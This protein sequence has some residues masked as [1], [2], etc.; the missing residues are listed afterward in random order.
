MFGIGTMLIQTHVLSKIDWNYKFFCVDPDP[1]TGLYGRTG[2]KKFQ[3]ID[4]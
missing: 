3:G 4:M 1:E 2:C